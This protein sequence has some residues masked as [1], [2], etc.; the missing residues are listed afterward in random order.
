MRIRTLGDLTAG[1]LIPRAGSEFNLAPAVRGLRLAKPSSQKQR[2]KA[3]AKES[4]KAFCK[5]YLKH[6]FTAGFNELHED[7]FTA[8]D[9]PPPKHRGKRVARIAPRKFGKTTII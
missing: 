6:H 4:L 8:C 2:R 9:S 3:K 5:I 7:I 1:P